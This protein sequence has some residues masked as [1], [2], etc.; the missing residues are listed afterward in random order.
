MARPSPLLMARPLVED[1]FFCGYPK[2]P[3]GGL[4]EER[5]NSGEMSSDI[6]EGVKKLQQK[7]TRHVTIEGGGGDLKK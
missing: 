1:F 6:R 5:R 2:T 4:N 3:V 7:H